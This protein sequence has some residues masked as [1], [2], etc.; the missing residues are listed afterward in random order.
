MTENV[1]GKVPHV[2]LAIAKTK[3]Q[4]ITDKATR[5]TEKMH[6]DVTASLDQLQHSEPVAKNVRPNVKTVADKVGAGTRAAKHG[7]GSHMKKM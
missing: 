6:D 3:A 4:K 1:K 5:T 2:S 7:A